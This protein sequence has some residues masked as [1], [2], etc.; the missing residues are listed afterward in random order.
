MSSL[1]REI[2]LR[3]LAAGL[4]PPHHVVIA[5]SPVVMVAAGGLAAGVWHVLGLHTHSLR[6]RILEWLNRPGDAAGPIEQ[7]V[8]TVTAAARRRAQQGST[9][10]VG[11]HPSNSS[12]ED[13]LVWDATDGAVCQRVCAMSIGP[14]AGRRPRAGRTDELGRRVLAM[15]ECIACGD[16][17]GLLAERDFSVDFAELPALSAALFGTSAVL[18]QR[19]VRFALRMLAA[20]EATCLLSPVQPG[21]LHRDF[22]LISDLPVRLL[23]DDP[24][25]AWAD[26][27]TLYALRGVEAGSSPRAA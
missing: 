17:D 9:A 19:L 25:C 27:T 1:S 6:S 5:P 4:R 3:Y 22:A 23:L 12:D 16:R 15:I 26:G 10:F 18:G 2:A 20:G 11:P 14:R 21:V 24:F 7:A 13:E 8:R